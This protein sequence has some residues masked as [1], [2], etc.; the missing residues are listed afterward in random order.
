[1]YKKVDLEQLINA[2][3]ASLWG[4]VDSGRPSWEMYDASHTVGETITHQIRQIKSLKTR[5]LN[6]QSRLAVQ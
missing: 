3:E 2:R 5:L 4:L 6:E 1:M